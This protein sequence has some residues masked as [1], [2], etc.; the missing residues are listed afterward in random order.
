MD[1]LNGKH[2]AGT[3][4]KSDSTE[5]KAGVPKIAAHI[6]G[7]VAIIDMIL[8]SKKDRRKGLGTAA[9]KKWEKELP[10]NIK[11]VRVF[12]ADT[13]DGNSDNFWK[14]LGFNYVY[15]DPGFD[16]ESIHTMWKAVNGHRIPQN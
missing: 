13:G 3:K 7:N 9:Y 10:K 1:R 4:K 5:P 12:A 14:S 16:Y 15:D 2:T 8:V 11:L 6:S